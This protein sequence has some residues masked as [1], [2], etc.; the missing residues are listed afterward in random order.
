MIELGFQMKQDS[1]NIFFSS[2]STHMKRNEG[3]KKT[4]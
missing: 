2:S 1:K 3:G 4:V